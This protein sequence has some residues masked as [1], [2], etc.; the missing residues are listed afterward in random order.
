MSQIKRISTIEEL[1]IL[2]KNLGVSKTWKK[3]D[4][5][6]VTAEHSGKTFLNEGIW[7][8]KTAIEPNSLEQYITIYKDG[9]PVAEVNLVSLFSWSTLER[10]QA[11]SDL[12]FEK[13]EDL[14]DPKYHPH[15]DLEPFDD[16]LKD[17]LICPLETIRKTY[18]D[19]NTMVI[20]VV[21]ED[22]PIRNTRCLAQ[23]H[24]DEN[25]IIISNSG[26]VHEFQCLSF[27]TAFSLLHDLIDQEASQIE[28]AELFNVL[29]KVTTV[30]AYELF[31]TAI[32][33]NL[34]PHINYYNVLDELHQDPDNILYEA[35]DD[36]TKEGLE[37][38]IGDEELIE[39]AA[40]HFNLNRDT[41]M[42]HGTCD[43][44]SDE[45]WLA[46]AK[47]LEVEIPSEIEARILEGDTD[48]HQ[49]KVSK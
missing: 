3:A 45:E 34:L 44:L 7:G 8:H 2:T 15:F 26:G 37:K 30:D 46:L 47:E 41:I 11:I 32:E 6:N 4:E 22:E 21:L 19:Y 40:D 27:K 5:Q 24:E 1:E 42:E 17:L 16:F 13:I 39:V 12:T 31:S 29:S 25:K 10:M 23:I 35:L 9:S 33:M 43:K 48:S 28:P 18:I 38:D 49:K 20:V 36:L 14:E